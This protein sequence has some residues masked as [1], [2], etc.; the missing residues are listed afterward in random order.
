M[1]RSDM[2]QQLAAIINLPL[3]DGTSRAYLGQS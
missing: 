3:E 1:A 2:H